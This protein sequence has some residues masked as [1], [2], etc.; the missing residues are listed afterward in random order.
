MLVETDSTLKVK[1]VDERVVVVEN[2]DSAF[3]ESSGT[4]NVYSLGEIVRVVA[5][6]ASSTEVEMVVVK[7]VVTL[8]NVTCVVIPSAVISVTDESIS[9][10]VLILSVS[11]KEE[12][13][14]V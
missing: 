1:T 2:E 3:L 6:I 5:A 10:I 9:T 12:V 13:E 4:V 11:S 14:P 8:S 7:V